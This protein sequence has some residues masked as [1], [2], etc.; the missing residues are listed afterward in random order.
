MLDCPEN[1]RWN[2][3]LV[4]FPRENGNPKCGDVTFM[5]VFD[6]RSGS[7]L[8]A[9]LGSMQTLFICFLLGF[10]AMTFSQDA[11]R[12]V[13][14][15]IERM[16]SKL[17]KIRSCPLEAVAIS[18]EECFR[19]NAKRY[20]GAHGHEE[21]ALLAGN[22]AH[23]MD[24]RSD[25]GGEEKK[26]FRTR[27]WS[28]LSCR[29]DKAARKEQEPLETVVLEKTIIKIGSL[30][31]LSLGEGGSEVMERALRGNDSASLNVFT[32]G[33]QLDVVMASCGV[34]SFMDVCDAMKCSTVV[35]VNRITHIVHL[36]AN[37]YSGLPNQSNGENYL[38][39]WRL[40][41]TDFPYMH[42]RMA[43]LCL[44]CAAEM[45][46]KL[47]KSPLVS[48][49]RH[50]NDLM[51]RFKGKFKVRMD[52]G[53][54]SGWAIECAIGS[55]FKID[56]SYLSPHITMASKLEKA[57][58][59]YGRQILMSESHV[60]LMSIEL[61]EECRLIDT[62]TMPVSPGEPPAMDG[63]VKLYC[64]DLDDAVIDTD[65]GTKG[66]AAWPSRGARFKMKL[67]RMKKRQERSEEE[68]AT[69]SIF[70][71]NNVDS[72]IGMMRRKYTQQ[73]FNLFAMGYENFVAGEWA[74]ART[75]FQDTL[76][77]LNMEDRP[78]AV[79]L[80]FMRRHQ[81]TPPVDWCGVRPLP[82]P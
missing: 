9:V 78:S 45:T 11:N 68:F 22:P 74:R 61:Q 71:A 32:R 16:I 54:H 66:A 46:A 65:H 55:E 58:R 21:V 3:R 38:L 29:R 15:P 35:F 63:P 44:A 7:R 5:F 52:F 70:T 57:A 34:R 53:T 73:F 23:S 51:T 13:L 81:W 1:L 4:F 79:L 80:R 2:E 33:R 48:E 67:D 50:D 77:Y 18:E 31:A 82:E 26:S 40:K 10:G 76:Q 62:V 19:E 14:R 17:E 30:L 42:G 6:R 27:C 60:N 75:I 69:K 36:C 72:D 39:I 20:F 47:S 64:F 28:L 59:E 12:L 43:D 25:A 37:E 49:Y 24:L 41:K 56:V 8:E